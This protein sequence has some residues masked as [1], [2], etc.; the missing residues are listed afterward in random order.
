MTLEGAPSRVDAERQ[1]FRALLENRLSPEGRP[2]LQVGV[3]YGASNGPFLLDGGFRFGLFNLDISLDRFD[4]LADAGGGLVLLT[5][6]QLPPMTVL[7]LALEFRGEAL[8]RLGDR[9]ESIRQDLQASDGLNRRPDK[10]RVYL[11]PDGLRLSQS[12][13]PLVLSADDPSLGPALLSGRGIH[14]DV[15]AGALLTPI[16][17]T[18]LG[19]LGTLLSDGAGFVPVA[20]LPQ[21][22]V[23][24]LG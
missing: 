24:S 12:K 17:H 13:D 15:G 21:K 11:M 5:S 22:T 3:A 16:S 14:G 20:S 23:I 6:L 18:W 4:E 19:H 8:E 7:N 10:V 1:I 9:I 2:P